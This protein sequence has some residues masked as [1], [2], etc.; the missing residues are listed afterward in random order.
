M[1]RRP[2]GIPKETVQLQFAHRVAEEAKRR[3][4]S[5]A[6]LAARAARNYPMTATT[7]WKIKN[8]DPPRRVDLDEAT[9]IALGAF[10]YE[11]IEAFLTDS[12]LI[13][14]R[15]DL[16]A[17]TTI[18]E[19][20]ADASLKL[21]ELGDALSAHL[22]TKQ[23]RDALDDPSSNM[24]ILLDA[25]RLA[26]GLESLTKGLTADGHRVARLLMTLNPSAKSVTEIFGEGER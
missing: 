18:C 16:N 25:R 23:V 22:S 1:P 11:T 15:E 13:R 7:I 6:S 4:W 12:K 3:G 21:D 24:S 10:G 26:D 8:A 19:A 14:L 20:L 5:D 9:A 17:L 2:S